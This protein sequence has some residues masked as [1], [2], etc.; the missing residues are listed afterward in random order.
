MIGVLIGAVRGEDQ[1]D[2]LPTLDAIATEPPVAPP[3]DAPA[4][5]A[6]PAVVPTATLAPIVTHPP[7]DVL[8]TSDGALETPTEASTEVAATLDPE[9]TVEPEATEFPLSAVPVIEVGMI[10][11]AT[12]LSFELHNTG[13]AMDSAGSYVL[14]PDRMVFGTEIEDAEVETARSG[15]KSG[16]H[17]RERRDLQHQQ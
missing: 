12:A 14:T 4:T 3:V 7:M 2:P 13:S 10:C 15:C 11:D 8:P 9:V 5:D 1:V 16:L 6:P 17:F